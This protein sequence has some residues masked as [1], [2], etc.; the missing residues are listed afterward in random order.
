MKSNKNI[1]SKGTCFR[2]KINNLRKPS[3]LLRQSTRA[4]LLQTEAF[5]KTLL[6]LS[7]SF[8]SPPFESRLL[9]WESV[10]G[11]ENASLSP[12]LFSLQSR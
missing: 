12:T 5:G 3:L 1:L 9:F 6:C 4:V 8:F 10:L 2:D 7:T 11:S